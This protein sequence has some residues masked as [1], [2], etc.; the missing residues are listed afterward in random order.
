MLVST[1]E[2]LQKHIATI[3]S[4]NYEKYESYIEDANAWVRRELLGSTLYDTVKDLAS[5]DST[6][7]ELVKRAE[8]VV[9]HKAYLDAVP[10][11][12]LIETDS[13][14]A[15]IKTDSKAPASKE[16]VNKLVEGIKVKLSDAID[17]L[18]DYLEDNEMYHEAWKVSLAYSLLTDTFIPTLREF[19]R[20]AH[21]EGNRLDYIKAKPRMLDIMNNVMSPVISSELI[22]EITEQLKDDDI[23]PKNLLL[24]DKLKYAFALFTIGQERSASAYLN[25]VRKIIIAAPD[26]YPAFANSELYA[27]IIVQTS[28]ENSGT[29]FRTAL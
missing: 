24:V 12:D 3:V 25:K 4:N 13:G 19:N 2:T 18:I 20:Y 1:I 11:L 26:D 16:R 15:V 9:A 14:F 5:S 10:F 17:E 21:F 6:H 23:T 22:D 27:K 8:R 7:G 29:I 28:F